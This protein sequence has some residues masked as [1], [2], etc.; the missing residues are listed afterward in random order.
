MGVSAR[1][2][3][4]A[5]AAA[6]NRFLTIRTAAEILCVSGQTIRRLIYEGELPAV[7]VGSLLRI[8]RASLEEYLEEQRISLK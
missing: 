1:N 8:P 3:S 4:Q 5:P 6:E 7:R 2:M